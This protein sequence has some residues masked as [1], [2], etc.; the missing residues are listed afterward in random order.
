MFPGIATAR[1]YLIP[2][3]P[4]RL[5]VVRFS[6]LVFCDSDV[7]F[8]YL[9]RVAVRRWR[10][11]SGE[12]QRR[13]THASDRRS[14]SPLLSSILNY[15]PMKTLEPKPLAKDRDL[16]VLVVEDEETVSSFLASSL[17]STG[18]S[19]V[20]TCPDQPTALQRLGELPH[21]RIALIID[22]ALR[23]D[24]GIDLAARLLNERPEARVLLISGF[25]DE[26]VLPT[27]A[28]DSHRV[29]FLAK[30][31]NLRQFSTEFERLLAR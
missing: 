9:G 18:Y 27:G 1:R 23:T 25:I 14:D 7:R 10:C 2:T 16:P 15:P 30:P 20:H 13:L 17:R 31:F 26:M 5:I 11:C 29:A 19:N 8:D 28:A 4:L 22:V 3:A 24:N 6:S 12:G 21:G